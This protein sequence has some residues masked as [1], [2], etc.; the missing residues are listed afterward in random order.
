MTLE[1]LISIIVPVYNTA[2]YLER[3]INSLLNQTYRTIEIILINDGSTDESGAICDRYM[4]EDYRIV[5][6]HQMNGGPMAACRAGIS[7]SKGEYLCFMDSDDRVESEMISEM[8]GQL[9]FDIDEVVCCNIITERAYGTF[10]E[11][12]GLP[13]GEYVD[14]RHREIF[15]NILGN[16][17]RQIILSRCMK[18]ISRNLVINNLEYNDDDLK[19]GEDSVMTLPIL[20]DS[21][22]IVIMEDAH[23]YHYYY[24]DASLVHGYI[25]D[26]YKHIC[27]LH[28][29]LKIIMVSKV[30]QHNLDI[31]NDEIEAQCTREHLIMLMVALK[32]EAKG[33]FSY[34]NYKKNALEIC[35]N[36]KTRELTGK[37]PLNV[38][39][40]ASRTI[41]LVLK[42]PCS[43]TIL[44]LR[45][46]TK[47]FY[48][49][50]N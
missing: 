33:N 5:T 39:G 4:K 21:K 20:F 9:K 30:I 6:L 14:N 10:K 45:C 2:P 40:L 35:N 1:P 27:R 43:L 37:Y 32:N 23:F 26:L 22:R 29:N 11:Q 18:L 13:P 31:T 3:C 25:P 50:R 19:M 17:K 12:H 38:S 48:A 44:L 28:Q 41:Y 49:R 8:V 16:E 34:R 46:A 42:Y 7:I 24:N 36:E 47:I 15:R